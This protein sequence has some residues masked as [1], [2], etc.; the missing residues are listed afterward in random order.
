M[1]RQRSEGG[2]T[3]TGGGRIASHATLHYAAAGRVA[4][5]TFTQPELSE[6]SLDDLN[7]VVA[8]VQADRG[9][10]TLVIRGRGEVFC[11]GIEAE[12]IASA[13]GDLEYFEHVL[14]RIAATCLSLE[15]L[16]VP[17]IAAVNGR[18]TAAG[19]ELALACDMIVTA[20]DAQLGDA[21][22][23]SG[24]IPGGG[25]TVR[26]PRAVGVQHARELIYS[27]R[28]VG[29]RE[30]AA[31]GLALRSV[32]AADLDAAVEALAATLTGKSRQA[33]AAAKRQING[34]LGRDT[35][36]G[37]EHE[38]GEFIRYL[39]EPDSDA[40]EGFRAATEGRPPSWA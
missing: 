4:Q 35:P 7:D 25:S 1:R 12:L 40:I 15:A 37:V 9:L 16:E 8:R 27:G 11:T 18:A 39:R 36:T 31:L 10:R 24:M 34:G 19:L 20:D 30:A 29:G 21:Q 17:V 32:P 2:A 6:A 3:V 13:F 26:L 28:L 33:L 14:T 38:R 22:L 23:D 5:A